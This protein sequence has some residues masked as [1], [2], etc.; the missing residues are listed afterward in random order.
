MHFTLDLNNIGQFGPD[1]E[2]VNSENYA[3]DYNRVKA[4]NEI[5]KYCQNVMK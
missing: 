4:Y 1:T 5:K 3:V 2:W